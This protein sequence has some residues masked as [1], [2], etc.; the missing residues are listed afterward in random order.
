MN[1]EQFCYWLKG[2]F[3]LSQ[4]KPLSIEQTVIIKEHLDLV[5]NKVTVSSIQKA[6]STDLARNSSIQLTC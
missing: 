6:F 2:H 3:E 1:S 4:N 5:F